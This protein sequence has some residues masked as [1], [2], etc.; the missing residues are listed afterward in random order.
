MNRI[1]ITTEK[2]ADGTQVVRPVG[3]LDVFSFVEFK[4]YLEEMHA[5]M[6]K[7]M[8]V[9]DLSGVEYIAS[10][11][12]SVLLARRQAFRRGGGDLAICGLSENLRRV[13][14]TMKIDKLL[15]A[16]PDTGEAVKLLKSPEEAV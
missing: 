5:T 15:P 12:W 11:G 8:V 10:S 13:Y 1:E 4:K 3:K 2:R 6:Q 9:V 16:G 7:S 14:D